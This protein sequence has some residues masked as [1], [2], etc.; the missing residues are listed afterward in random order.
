MTNEWWRE[1]WS[2]ASLRNIQCPLRCLLVGPQILTSLK[3][4]RLTVSSPFPAG[5]LHS[6]RGAH[7]LR[8]ICQRRG[9]CRRPVSCA[10]PR[11]GAP[12][13]WRRLRPPGVLHVRLSYADSAEG[14][15]R[16]SPVPRSAQH[17]APWRGTLRCAVRQP[18][19]TGDQREN[20][21][22]FDSCDFFRDAIWLKSAI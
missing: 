8:A 20:H 18:F 15:G 11:G 2:E 9:Q 5:V 22:A 19:W 17:T 13:F 6:S 4:I 10:D 14:C 3:R 12:S 21:V 16:G 7:L 1:P